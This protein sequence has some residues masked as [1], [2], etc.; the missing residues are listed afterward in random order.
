MKRLE[1]IK[2]NMRLSLI[3]KTF[4]LLVLF[5]TNAFSQGAPTTQGKEFWVS[6]GGVGVLDASGTSLQVRMIATRATSVTLT[7]TALSGGS[8][9]QTFNLVAGQVY[10]HEL[11]LAQ[12]EAVYHGR[13][14]PVGTTNRSLRITSNENI[15]VFAINLRGATT[16]ATNVLPVSNLGTEYFNLSY[17][18][19]NPSSSIRYG[20][21][22]IIIASASGTTNVRNHLGATIP[23]TQGQVYS[24]YTDG[25][26]DLT[27]NRITSDKPVAVFTTNQGTMI[28]FGVY[29][30]DILY[31]QLAPVSSWG[32]RFIVPV[33]SATKGSF[34]RNRDRIRIL[35]SQNGTKITRTGGTVQTNVS[36]ASTN[37]N[38]LNAG[39]FVE[40][41][42]SGNGCYISADKPIAVASYLISA[43]TFG[44][45][46]Q[47]GDPAMAWVPPIEQTVSRSAIAP[48]F[49]EGLSI[50][51]DDH[52]YALIVTP[53]ATK[54]ETT[55]AINTGTP[56]PLSGGTWID[57]PASGYSFYKYNFPSTNKTDVYYIENHAGFSVLG[58]G[59]GGYESY[60]Y[61]A[62]AAARNLTASFYINNIHNQDA[63]GTSICNNSLSFRAE[64][65]FAMSTAPGHIRW[66]VN[67][68][69]VAVQ[70]QLQWTVPS[71]PVGTYPI[72]MVVTDI[73][74]TTVEVESTITVAS[75]MT[76]GSI[77]GSQ[78]I[79]S[80]ATPAALTSITSASGGVGMITYQW[81]SSTN[82][83][84]WTNISG[85]T[86]G[87][88]YSPGTLT[89]TTYYRRAA[90][91]T[92]GTVYTSSVQITV[93]AIGADIITANGTT[94]CSGEVAT[95]SASAGS[96]TG[97]T[98]RWYNAA[99]GGS[100]L[101]T[102]ATYNP[103]PT[104]T[105]TYYVSVSGTSQG[106][107]SRKAVTVTVK[108]TAT[109][110][111]IKI[112]Q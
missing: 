61:L 74:D 91:S 86:N 50:L 13:N 18:S 2:I 25:Q 48:F 19:H 43:S 15:S 1:Q 28:P 56:Q 73:D 34:T 68:Q 11:T 79:V 45:S 102:G 6:W 49:S 20:D 99:T 92:C 108:P 66:Y 21:S 80:G 63:D 107:S 111:M 52:H 26:D 75:A 57:N 112:T 70:D 76:S 3:I 24:F 51:Q 97:P 7:Y 82:G 95:L 103:V 53:T 105:T 32:N 29:A 35:A 59:L 69:E 12:K 94:I 81:Q 88:S 9:T 78:S 23:L 47:L 33:T 40:L 27:G 41:E 87:S 104:S 31:Q 101:S 60:Y 93:T 96:V 22:Y 100:L 62:A 71:L 72:K 8:K 64:I 85:A 58:Y 39:Q 106:E 14:T 10:T 42:I 98:F 5:S 4:L 110:D 109:P 77:T 90:T 84:S 83:T 30:A 17:M 55:I 67:N 89:A 65:N 37:L 16:D 54:N 44:E 38:N 46:D 36:G